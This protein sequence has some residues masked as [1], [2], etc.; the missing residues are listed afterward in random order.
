MLQLAFVVCLHVFLSFHPCIKKIKPVAHLIEL[1]LQREQCFDAL[2][3]CTQSGQ[4]TF[5]LF[6]PLI[7]ILFVA[8]RYRQKCSFLSFV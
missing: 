7:C 1:E 6:P 5:I 8:S 3:E 2:Q 4:V